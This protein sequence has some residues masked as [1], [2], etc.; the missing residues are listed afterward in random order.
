MTPITEVKHNLGHDT[1]IDS[2]AR[3]RVEG[4]SG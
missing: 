3:K 2:A 1:A 4:G